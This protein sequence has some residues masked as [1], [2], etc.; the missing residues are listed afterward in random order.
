MPKI[1]EGTIL[2]SDMPQNPL[3]PSNG[4]KTVCSHYTDAK[5]DLL[6]DYSKGKLIESWMVLIGMSLLFLTITGILLARTRSG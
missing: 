5:E 3:N 6:L 4:T 1:V 2:C